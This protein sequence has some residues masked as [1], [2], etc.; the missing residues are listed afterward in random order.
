MSH[1]SITIRADW[2]SVDEKYT[3]PYTDILGLT[4]GR[5]DLEKLRDK[6][7][8]IGHLTQNF[9]SLKEA[10]PGRPVQITFDYFIE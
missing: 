9:I 6:L 5:S 7:I 3:D 2:D 10:T 4:G 8:E 1:A